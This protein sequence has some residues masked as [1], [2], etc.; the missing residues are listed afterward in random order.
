MITIKTNA[1]ATTT[2]TTVSYVQWK[3]IKMIERFETPNLIINC[4]MYSG[5][6]FQFPFIRIDPL[7]RLNNFDKKSWFILILTFFFAQKI[8]WN[9][10]DSL[11]KPN[12]LNC[13]FTFYFQT[14]AK[15][16]HETWPFYSRVS[17]CLFHNNQTISK[18]K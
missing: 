18:S 6:F 15:I 14:K 10:L 8:F 16:Q 2:T 3:A 17:F 12:H 4:C 1:T 9:W 5:V 11:K 7:T 13:N